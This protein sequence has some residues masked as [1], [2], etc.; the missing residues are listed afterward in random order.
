M[1]VRSLLRDANIRARLGYVAL[2]LSGNSTWSALDGSLTVTGG[3]VCTC[4]RCVAK[5]DLNLP[6]RQ[7]Q[8]ADQLIQLIQELVRTAAQKGI[9][10]SALFVA[11]ESGPIIAALKA[12]MALFAKKAGLQRFEEWVRTGKNWPGDPK[13]AVQTA[14]EETEEEEEEED[15]NEQQKS[16]A[17]D[18]EIIR[19]GEQIILPEAMSLAEGIDWLKKKMVADEREVAVSEDIRGYVLDGAQAFMLALKAI[20]GF[21]DTTATPGFWG[22]TPPTFISVET[23]VNST[24]Q[25]AWGR[26]LVPGIEGYLQT[27]LGQIDGRFFFS[28]RGQVKKKDLHK[29]EKIAATT[30]E[31]LKSNSIYRGKA[32]RV[33]FP[34]EGAAFGPLDHQPKF[35]DVS[36]VNREELVLSQ[37]VEDD[38]ATSLFTPI[39]NTQACR[40]VKIPLKR[41]VLLHG[42][43]G[44]GKTL[45]AYVTAQ[46]CEQHGWTF[47][48][49]KSVTQLDQ[50][51][52][53]AKQYQPCVI[54]AEDID[55]A[56]EDGDRDESMNQ[57]LNTID[58]V[59]TK[60]TEIIVVLSTNFVEKIN[61]AM[62]RPGRLDAAIEVCP[63]DAGAIARLFAIY[64]RGLIDP[65]E[66]LS[67]PAEI[68]KGTIPAFVREAI[69]RAKLA[70]VRASTGG[71]LKITADDLTIAARGLK[72]HLALVD[73]KPIREPSN[74]ERAAQVLG[75]TLATALMGAS[76]KGS[77]GN[78]AREL[79]AKPAKPALAAGPRS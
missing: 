76:E 31:M 72:A 9:E 65:K 20:Y 60:G 29:V 73:R 1:N 11:L 54:F 44:T 63:P 18:V 51:I 22:D 57:V 69:E 43:Y 16:R 41:G 13:E 78:G 15:M 8:T 74:R 10:P 66:D 23:G 47:L 42:V 38:I 12:F 5:R 33:T 6:D 71:P 52:L 2:A 17:K 58:G 46:L 53:F 36:T 56:M 67:E 50:A 27:G 3:E 30:R 32:V 49:L 21:V 4:E 59:D 28:I 40:D 79:P 77:N 35:I 25:V 61:P 70:A 24:I 75:T 7:V 45:S 14:E 62:L 39:T 68:L 55:Q 48:Y 19:G 26:I 37:N 34:E 64:G